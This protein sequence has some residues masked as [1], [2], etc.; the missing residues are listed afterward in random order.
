MNASGDLNINNDHQM[1]G[2]MLKHLQGLLSELESAGNGPDSEAR[3]ALTRL[4]A[5]LQTLEAAKAGDFDHINPS[6]NPAIVK[7]DVTIPQQMETLQGR[8]GNLER[9]LEELPPGTK[10]IL[11]SAAG[12]WIDEQLHTVSGA[13]EAVVDEDAKETPQAPPPP[14]PPLS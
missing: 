2:E 11:G 7:N 4:Q 10:E 5:S 1:S 8:V 3:E 9:R 6:D 12:E 14:Q 13:V